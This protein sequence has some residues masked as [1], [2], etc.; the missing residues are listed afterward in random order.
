MLISVRNLVAVFYKNVNSWHLW[1]QNI[2][3]YYAF[4]S[5]QLPRSSVFAGHIK[6]QIYFLQA[7]P[8]RL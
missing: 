7:S 1:L 4:I 6:Y 8:Q 2:F 3:I 5:I